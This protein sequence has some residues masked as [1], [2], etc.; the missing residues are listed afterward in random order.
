M[1]LIRDIII[2][3]GQHGPYFKDTLW[4]QFCSWLKYHFNYVL[5]K[6]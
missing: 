2:V 5:F 6:Q 4:F 1:G 3:A